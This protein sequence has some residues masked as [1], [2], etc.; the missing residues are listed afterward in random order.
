M[1]NYHQPGA[2]QDFVAPSGGVV[3]GGFYSF[4]GLICCATIDALVGETFPGQIVGVFR[5][6]KAGSEAWAHGASIYLTAGSATL[7]TTTSGGNT[8]AGKAAGVVGSGAT[9]TEGLV[10]LNGLPA[11]AV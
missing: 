8:L 2:V 9:E 6:T 7:F 10:L 4:N 3:S 11:A 1:Q 5:V